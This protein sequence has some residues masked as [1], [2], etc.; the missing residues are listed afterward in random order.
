M[1]TPTILLAD[2]HSLVLKGVQGVLERQYQVIGSAGDGK[3]L[4]EAALRLK[5]DVV[6]LDISMPVLN[7]IDAAIEIRNALPATR[8]VFL[9][10]HANAI[11]LR[12]AMAAGASAYVLKSAAVEELVSA[13]EAARIGRTYISPDFDPD[14]LHDV[15]HAPARSLQT[16]VDL[17][18]RQRQVLQ[19][20]A[21]G[22][23][24]KEIAEIMHVSVKTVEFHRGRL[25]S[26]LG[27]R[28]VAELTRFAIQEGLIDAAP[29][30]IKPQ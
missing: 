27:L 2:D 17:S 7:G 10:M 3:A 29:P 9:T 28:T 5:P 1:K 18:A 25:M 12:K 11:Y 23:Q 15:Q 6:V 13:I 26:K 22:R 4:V 16:S 24:S 8:L 20:I 21:E 30:V 14:V 19:L